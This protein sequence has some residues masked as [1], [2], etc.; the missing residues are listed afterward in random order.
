MQ[1]LALR[2]EALLRLN[3]LEEADSTVTSLLKLDSASLSSMSTKLSGM[4]ADSYVHVVQAQVNMAFGRYD[5]KTCRG[6]MIIFL[7]CYKH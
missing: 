1:L 4:V 7:F 6:T 5:S 2:S 3:K